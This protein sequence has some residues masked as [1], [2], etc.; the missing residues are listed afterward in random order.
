MRLTRLTIRLH[1]RQSKLHHRMVSD[2]HLSSAAVIMKLSR[3]KS[4]CRRVQRVMDQ[5]QRMQL[6]LQARWLV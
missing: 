5:V 6:S 1:K 2:S 4:Q 3:S